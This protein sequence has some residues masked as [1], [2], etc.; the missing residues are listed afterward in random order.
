MDLNIVAHCQFD[1]PGIRSPRIFGVWYYSI[2]LVDTNGRYAL[3]FY[4]FSESRWREN[5]YKNRVSKLGM[6]DQSDILFHQKHGLIRGIFCFELFFFILFPWSRNVN[7]ADLQRLLMKGVSNKY[8][9]PKCERQLNMICFRVHKHHL[10]WTLIQNVSRCGSLEYHGFMGWYL[11]GWGWNVIALSIFINILVTLMVAFLI[12]L[13][14]SCSA[15]ISLDKNH[16]I[17]GCFFKKIVDLL[18]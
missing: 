7:V 9:K 18:Q 2:F 6:E 16:D 10:V 13:A 8:N 15:L 14:G 5:L 12:W 4:W 17:V 3:L 11:Y 1:F